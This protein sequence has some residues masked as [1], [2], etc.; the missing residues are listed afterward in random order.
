MKFRFNIPNA[1][2][3]LRVA[4]IPVFVAVFSSDIPYK[5]LASAALFLAISFSDMLDGHLA[6]KLKQVTE[7]GKLIDPIADKLLI[8]TVLIVLIGQ[9]VDLWMALVIIAREVI[10]TAARLYLLKSHPVIPASFLG[11]SKTFIQTFAIVFAILG[12]R[13]SWHLMLIAVILTVVSGIEYVFQIKKMTGIKVVNI[14]NIITLS[15][16]LLIIPYVY[17]LYEGHTTNS[18]ILF[19]IISI[20]DKLDGISARWMNQ[21]TKLGSILDSFTDWTLIT[22]FL[23]MGYYLEYYNTKIF[24]ALI[25]AILIIAAAKIYKIGK[26]KPITPYAINKITVGWAYVTIISLMMKFTY[27]GLMLSGVVVLTYVM[28]ITFALRK[29]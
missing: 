6:R 20:S 13:F 28:A 15:R 3:L 23:L 21:V 22:S 10:L 26:K 25:I 7:F 2:T 4:L 11:K 8:S 27:S 29:S 24:I 5:N 18:I 16:L 12:F 9:G 19:A 1:I 17:N 14:P